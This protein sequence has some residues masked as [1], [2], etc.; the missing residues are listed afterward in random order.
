MV[1][2]A[3]VLLL[4]GVTLAQ[5]H[6]HSEGSHSSHSQEGASMDGC[7]M[8]MSQH[9]Q[10]SEKMASMDNEMN[11]LVNEIKLAFGESKITAME[12]LLIALVEQRTSMHSE[13]VAMM[14]RVMHHMSRHVGNN[15][16]G[17]PTMQ[18]M[19]T[20]TQGSEGHDHSQHH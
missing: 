17:C 11:Q 5:S 9:E 14:P 1:I 18:G 8:M 3:T 13:M 4:G 2:L 20:S 12:K 6:H 15:D 10:M 16:H 19:N 7:H